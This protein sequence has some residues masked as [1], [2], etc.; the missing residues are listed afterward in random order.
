MFLSDKADNILP[1]WCFFL[2]CVLNVE[3]LRPTASREGFYED[4]DLLLL[5]EEMGLIVRDYFLDLAQTQ[6][7]KLAKILLIHQEAFKSLAL[8]DDDFF[9]MMVPFLKF[10][11]TQGEISLQ[12]IKESPIKHVP[13]IDEFRKIAPIAHAQGILVINSGYMYDSALLRKLNSFQHLPQTETLDVHAFISIFEELDA[14]SS[15]KCEK[16]MQIARKVL[17]TFKCKPEL[18]AFHP[19]NLTGLYYMSDSVLRDRNIQNAMEKSDAL[20]GDVLGNFV[21]GYGA[22]QYSILCFNYQNPLIRHIAQVQNAEILENIVGILYVNALMLGH[23]PLDTQEMN[24]LNTNV[25]D[26]IGWAL[27]KE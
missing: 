7:D 1:P 17:A 24:I 6:P 16:F 22:T 27:D 8:E 18:K 12:E 23:H 25:L 5:R 13:N 9:E 20:W 10:H 3:Q 21:G 15:Q 11:S 4:D 14:E 2:K 26:L 19:S